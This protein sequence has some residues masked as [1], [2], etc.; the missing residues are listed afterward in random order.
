MPA[1]ISQALLRKRARENVT[2]RKLLNKAIEEDMA[3]KL[4]QAQVAVAKAMGTYERP[5][6][7]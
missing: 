7:H 3:A 1:D 6:T 5:T 4:H 2:A